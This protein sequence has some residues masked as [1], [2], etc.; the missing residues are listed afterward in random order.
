[1]AELK[2]LTALDL[3]F[4]PIT[5]AG[6][7]ELASLNNLTTLYLYG[8]QVTDAGLKELQ[9]AIPNCQIVK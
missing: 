7:K 9:Q 1:L 3:S 8:T 4:T 5:D 2:N 6:L